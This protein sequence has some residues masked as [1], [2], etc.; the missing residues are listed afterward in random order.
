MKNDSDIS[1]ISTSMRSQ[2]EACSNLKGEQVY[3]DIFFNHARFLYG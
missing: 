3:Y 2:L 1:R